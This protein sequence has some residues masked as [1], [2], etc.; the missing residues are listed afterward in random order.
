MQDLY[1]MGMAYY[2]D[3]WEAAQANDEALEQREIAE[4]FERVYLAVTRLEVLDGAQYLDLRRD[5]RF[6]ELSMRR[7]NGN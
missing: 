5:I 6:L 7:G 1:G 4:A 2:D 3:S